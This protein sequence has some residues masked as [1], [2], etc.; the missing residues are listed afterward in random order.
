MDKEKKRKPVIDDTPEPQKTSAEDDFNDLIRRELEGKPEPKPA[1]PIKIEPA[2][3]VPKVEPK[4]VKS[5]KPIMAQ[6]AKVKPFSRKPKPKVIKPRVPKK[7]D[8]PKE[9]PTPDPEPSTPVYTP[10]P[11]SPGRSRWMSLLIIILIAVGAVYGMNALR[12]SDDD[13]AFDCAVDYVDG[14]SGTPV[15]WDEAN[16]VERFWL[17]NAYESNDAVKSAR[18]FHMLACEEAFL[19][20]LSEPSAYKNCVTPPV[21][22]IIDESALSEN[23]AAALDENS[24]L[25]KL[26]NEGV[27]RGF[28]LVYRLSDPDVSAWQIQ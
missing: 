17:R 3:E 20:T 1:K 11:S 15:I 2:K 8:P 19:S 21:F 6:R 23:P 28:D 24:V 27:L 12:N 5:R 14:Q 16:A 4:V 26:A 10:P 25:T 18:I 13:G 22:V 7:I 9:A